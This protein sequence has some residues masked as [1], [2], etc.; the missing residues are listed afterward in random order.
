VVVADEA[1]GEGRR[2]LHAWLAAV[3]FGSFWFWVGG[4]PPDDG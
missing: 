4:V 1:P 2:A 3:N